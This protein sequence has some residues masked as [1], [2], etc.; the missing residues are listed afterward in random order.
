MSNN[1]AVTFNNINKT[2][3]R[4]DYEIIALDDLTLDI[5]KGDFF[6]LMGPSGSGKSTLL[7]LIAGIDTPS[8]GDL[9]VLNEDIFKKSEKELASW[10]GNN[11]GYIFQ[12]FNLIPVLTALENVEL[13]L[14]LTNLGKRDRMQ[15]ARTALEIVGLGD[16]KDHLPKQL[17]GGQE[18]RVAIARALVT[19]PEIILAD[20]PTGELDAKSAEDVLNILSKLNESHGKTIILVTHD[21]KAM[22]HA[23]NT[24][25][26][27]K[28]KL[29][30]MPA[31]SSQ[32]QSAPLHLQ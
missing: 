23:L 31:E 24:C 26:L 7:H 19:D 17:S 21:P 12:S 15:R 30:R 14:L 29:E 16:R 11:I 4:A 32:E 6:C 9:R 5:P 3:R 2:Y 13:P 22:K 27:D 25:H 20:E 1:A 18:Q 28:G 10:R 8:S